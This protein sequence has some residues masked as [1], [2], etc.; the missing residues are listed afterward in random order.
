MRG[1]VRASL[2]LGAL[3]SSLLFSQPT[4]GQTIRGTVVD[5]VSGRGI[6]KARV[7]VSG[8][9]LQATTDS[10]GRFAIPTPP[11]GEQVL[12]IHTPSLDSLSAAYSAQVTVSGATTNVFV[13]VPSALQIAATACGDRGFGSGGIVLGRLRVADD[14]T[15]GLAG[16]VSAE[17]TANGGPAPRSVSA[18]ADARGR[19]ALCGVPVDT[20]LVLRALTDRASGQSTG[21]HVLSVA[22]FARVEVLLHREVAAIATFAGVVT[23]SAGKPIAGTEVLLP[24]IGKGSVTNDEGAFALREIP[25]GVQRIL[26]RHVG[27]SPVESKLMFVSGRTIERHVTMTR[28]TTLDSVV[29]TE[30]AVDHQLDDFEENRKLGLGHFLTRAELATQEGRPTASVMASL[31]G[32]KVATAGPYAWAGSGR[33]NRTSLKNVP[34]GLDPAD[35]A[36]RAPLW[37]CYALVYVDDHL[38]FRGQKINNKWEPL[39]DINSISVS[40]IEAIEYYASAAETP[41]KYSTLNSQCGVIVIHT[42]RSHPRDTTSVAGR[43]PTSR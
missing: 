17:W 1:G 28:T 18:T 30:K 40:E 39:F 26:V 6:G 33:H 7:G 13:R 34:D 43:V 35:A 2:W 31:P 41:T 25:A 22:R 19:F 15:A 14:S 37:D 9:S 29:V 8:T 10:L 42:I 16:T 3:G 23:D 36:K 4:N 38:V 12:T 5:S 32:I 20:P 21:V 11:S 27:F 24:D